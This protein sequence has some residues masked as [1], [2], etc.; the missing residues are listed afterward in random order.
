M[1]KLAQ[2]KEK[3]KNLM[4]T[5]GW[6]AVGVWFAIFGLVLCGFAVAFSMGFSPDGK[7]ETTG[8]WGAAYIAPQL[9]KPLRI[10]AT[11]VLTPIVA[12]FLPQGR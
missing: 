12:R 9:T 6:V 7:A 2:L 4:A 1:K 8:V 11:L 3:L 10:A 5:Y